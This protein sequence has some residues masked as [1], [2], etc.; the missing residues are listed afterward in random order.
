M[1]FPVVLRLGPFLIPAYTLCMLSAVLVGAGIVFYEA[2]RRGRLTEPT[3]RVAFAALLGGA[4]G[5]KLSMLVFLGPAA[6]WRLLPTIPRHGAAF[7]GALIGGYVAAVLVERRLRIAGCTGDLLA[8]ALPLGQ[9][10]GRL[11]NYLAGDA[12]GLPTG[13]PWGVTMAGATRH[14]VQ[15]YEAALDLVLFAVIWRWRHRLSRDGDVFRLYVVGYALIRF[16]LEFLR[17]QPTP[18]DLLGL[19]LVQWLCLASIA[20]FGYQLFLSSRGASCICDLLPGAQRRQ[21]VS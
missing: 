6:F 20:G 11:G 12:Y 13:L 19:T 5:A 14:P 17:Y 8:P 18:R 7:T 4:L 16:P 15:F 2:R 9:A 1:A 21:V 10:I 3:L